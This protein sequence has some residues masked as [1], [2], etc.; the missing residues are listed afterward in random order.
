[1]GRAFHPRRARGYSIASSAATTANREADLGYR[2]S[3]GLPTRITQ[4]LSLARPTMEPD[5]SSLCGFLSPPPHNRL[6]R[7][8]PRESDRWPM[9]RFDWRP[10][11]P[12]PTRPPVCEFRRTLSRRNRVPR[13]RGAIGRRQ[14]SRRRRDGSLSTF[15]RT[16][17]RH[18][19]PIGIP[20]FSPRP[21]GLLL[22]G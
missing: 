8:A 7:A 21:L 3:S 5:S 15:S 1:M 9:R 20:F 11:R 2:S 13:W 4:R 22:P 16:P 12:S 6:N 19:A 14:L 18:L 10:P 17:R